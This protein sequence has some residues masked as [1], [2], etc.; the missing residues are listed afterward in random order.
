MTSTDAG[1]AGANNLYLL[2]TYND[3]T[4][5]FVQH[6]STVLCS[7]DIVFFNAAIRV[8]L[9]PPAAAGRRNRPHLKI[10]PDSSANDTF[11]EAVG[12]GWAGLGAVT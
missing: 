1:G 7:V 6:A 9:G 12:L 10:K 4:L 2:L 3:T 8:P 5:W 11:N